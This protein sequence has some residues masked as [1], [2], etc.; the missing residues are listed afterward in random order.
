MAEDVMTLLEEMLEES[1]LTELLDR[2]SLS[3]DPQAVFAEAYNAIVG[4]DDA[5]VDETQGRMKQYGLTIEK[6]ESTTT[7]RR[8]REKMTV[9]LGYDIKRDDGIG[10]TRWM[11]KTLSLGHRH[12]SL[13]FDSEA[14]AIAA[15]RIWMNLQEETGE[16]VDYPT[17]VMRT[18]KLPFCIMDDENSVGRIQLHVKLT[19]EESTKMIALLRGLRA[20]NVEVEPGVGV[21][22]YGSAFK[23]ILSQIELVK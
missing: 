20:K 22:G 16:E 3:D 21:S 12:Q 14:D 2:A 1:E 7:N 23:Y 9:L 4:D 10:A 6:I 17:P 15:A 5:P 11:G 18:I 19:L 13:P 8:T